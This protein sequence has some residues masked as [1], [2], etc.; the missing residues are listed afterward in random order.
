MYPGYFL[1]VFPWRRLLLL[2]TEGNRGHAFGFE[3]ATDLHLMV[4]NYLQFYT[5]GIGPSG[6][7]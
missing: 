1:W 3:T 2:W 4:L 5:M 6:L 7:L